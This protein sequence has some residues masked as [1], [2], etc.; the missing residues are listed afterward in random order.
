MR[1]WQTPRFAVV[2]KLRPSPG[3]VYLFFTI[4]NGFATEHGCVV[5]SRVVR[6]KECHIIS[7]KMLSNRIQ[8]NRVSICK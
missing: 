4:D 5:E 1:D 3:Y 6:L 2:A 8:S 7:A